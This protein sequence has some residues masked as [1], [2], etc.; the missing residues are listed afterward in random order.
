MVIFE[1]GT[2]IVTMN[3]RP[4]LVRTK[5]GANYYGPKF[6]VLR[7]N[8]TSEEVYKILDC[9][10][11]GMIPEDFWY[12]LIDLNRLEVCYTLIWNDCFKAAID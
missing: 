7:S 3:F 8:L 6:I 11:M 10:R 12:E 1:P 9:W 2:I 5:Y 4:T